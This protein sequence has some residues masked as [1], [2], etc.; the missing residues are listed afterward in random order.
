MKTSCTYVCAVIMYVHMY[1]ME[2]AKTGLSAH[3][4]YDFEETHVTHLMENV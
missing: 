1:M 4:N 2:Y 3:L